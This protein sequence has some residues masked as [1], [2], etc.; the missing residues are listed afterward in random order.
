MEQTSLLLSPVIFPNFYLFQSFKHF[1]DI[2]LK[3]TGKKFDSRNFPDAHRYKTIT[4]IVNI[5]IRNGKTSC[6][7]KKKRFFFL[8]SSPTTCN[9]KQ[10]EAATGGVL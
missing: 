6:T 3:P 7:Q 10:T 5:A 4:I 8:M 9:I 2:F 1:S